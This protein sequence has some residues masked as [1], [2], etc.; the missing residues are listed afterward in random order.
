MLP[1]NVLRRLKN[2]V[3]DKKVFVISD[4]ARGNQ[5]A[6]GLAKYCDGLYKYSEALKIAKP[7]QQKVNEMN[8]KLKVAMDNLDAKNKEV[9]QIKENL[10]LMEH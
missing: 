1:P 10:S 4:I 3:T 7:R 8:E 5:A 6:G 9:K 2:I